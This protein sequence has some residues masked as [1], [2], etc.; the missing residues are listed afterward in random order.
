MG[1]EGE[2]KITDNSIVNTATGTD[3]IFMGMETAASNRSDSLKSLKGV[4]YV[5]YEEA[6]TATLASLKKLDPTIRI[7]G[8]K[9]IFTMNPRT[10]TDAVDVYLKSYVMP[11]MV[12]TIDINYWDN[13]FCDDVLINQAEAMKELDY[14]TWLHIWA[15]QPIPED[16]S[17]II[18]PHSW[19]SQ[20]IDLHLKVEGKSHQ[21][22][23]DLW[24]LKSMGGFDVA[25]GTTDKHDKN[26]LALRRGPVIM[27]VEEWQLNEVYKSVNYINGQ[28][29]RLGLDTLY[30][31]ATAIGTAAKSEFDRL[32]NTVGLE[33]VVYPFK[34]G[35]SPYK[36][37]A[38]FTG[39]GKNKVSNG[40]MFANA[41]AQSWWNLRL[42]LENS[43]KLIK[44]EKLDRDDYYLSFSSAIP[45]LDSIFNEL[46]QATFEED[47]SGK[48][49]VDKAPGMHTV[50][51]EGKDKDRRS[52]NK[53][54]AIIYSFVGDLVRGLQAHKSVVKKAKVI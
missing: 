13:P 20:C 17:R 23:E 45:D 28:S 26:S 36:K 48:I 7:N 37:D 25:D 44:G 38:T 54:D 41:K 16:S 21:T 24:N 9:L 35:M 2:F 31:D 51:I 18:L 4:K 34:G 49:K 30:F 3:F 8:R 53:A 15:G 46:A 11:G 52:P 32:K 39:M 50:E 27:H 5:W 12:F 1:L 33:Y 42:R 43:L 14:D 22:A 6:Q 47:N 40:A 29:R 19:L 10:T